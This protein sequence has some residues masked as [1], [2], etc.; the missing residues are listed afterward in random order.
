MTQRVKTTRY[1]RKI[2]FI[3]LDARLDVKVEMNLNL[4]AYRG[5]EKRDNRPVQADGKVEILFKE[6]TSWYALDSD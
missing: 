2:N 3:K 6:L 1:E 4:R 5:K